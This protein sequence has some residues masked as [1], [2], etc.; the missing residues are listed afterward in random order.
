[1]ALG[2]GHGQFLGDGILPGNVRHS[3][4]RR[5]RHGG[6]HRVRAS[7]RSPESRRHHKPQPRYRHELRA[8]DSPGTGQWRLAL[9]AGKSEADKGRE[10]QHPSTRRHDRRHHR[11]NGAARRDRE[12]A[13]IADPSHAGRR[14]RRAVRRAGA[15]TQSAADRHPQQCAGTE[16]HD[17]AGPD[18][19]RRTEGRDRRHHRG[20][21]AGRKRHPSSAHAAE[22]R[23]IAR[24][25]HRR[26]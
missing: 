13:A 3:A 4:R 19:R 18:R 24:R 23:G 15:R 22:K 17:R 2:R 25:A 7:R 12:T 8:R 14:R 10:R 9:G 16:A 20:R 26:Q 11:K 6:H 5:I 21:C 1:M